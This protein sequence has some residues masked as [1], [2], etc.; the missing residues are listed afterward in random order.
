MRKTTTILENGSR[1]EA[2]RV[3]DEVRG[4]IED[5]KKESVGISGNLRN[6]K[7]GWNVVKIQN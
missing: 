4:S 3:F 5:F 6:K 2:Y 1:D 7:D